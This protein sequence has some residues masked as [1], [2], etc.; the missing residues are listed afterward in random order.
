VLNAST[1]VRV[2]C[3]SEPT[4]GEET[5]TITACTE[6]PLLGNRRAATVGQPQA[7]AGSSLVLRMQHPLRQCS[8]AQN[9]GVPQ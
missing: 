4:A 2:S 8:A 5:G 6:R 7:F 3:G 1:R 9:P